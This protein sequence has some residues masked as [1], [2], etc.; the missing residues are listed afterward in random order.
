MLRPDVFVYGAAV[1]CA[2]QKGWLGDRKSRGAAAILGSVILA[3]TTLLYH[4]EHDSFF[5]KIPALSLAPLGSALCMPWMLAVRP[6]PVI[7][8]IAAFLSTQA[9]ALCLVHF[10]VVMIW[11]DISGATTVAYLGSVVLSLFLANLL[12]LYIERPIMRRRPITA[13]VAGQELEKRAAAE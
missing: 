9:Y 10:P 13:P 6:I 12:H 2:L 3:T 1:Y 5:S 8:A 7:Q 11:A 4:Q